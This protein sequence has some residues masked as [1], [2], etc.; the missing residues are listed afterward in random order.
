[1][2]LKLGKQIRKASLMCVMTK[3]ELKYTNE[4]HYVKHI[5]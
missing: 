2:K 1:V 3:V 5:N 4:T